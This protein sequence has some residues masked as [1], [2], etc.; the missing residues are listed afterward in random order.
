[1]TKQQA[2]THYG[3][4]AALARALGVNRAAIN[5]WGDAIPLGRQFQ[6]EVLTGGV[7]KADRHTANDA[8]VVQRA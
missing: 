4:Q 8:P 3:T 2:I 6:L 7:L 5:G 1:M